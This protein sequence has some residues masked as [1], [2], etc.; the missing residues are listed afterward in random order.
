MLLSA[1]R[2][3][4]DAVY[5]KDCRGR[6]ASL[7]DNNSMRID[8]ISSRIEELAKM[9]EDSMGGDI[10]GNINKIAKYLDGS[11]DIKDFP[12]LEGSDIIDVNTDDKGEYTTVKEAIKKLYDQRGGAGQTGITYAGNE[13]GYIKYIKKQTDTTQ[14]EN[15]IGH[16]PT[17]F[18][19]IYEELNYLCKHLFER[20]DNLDVYEGMEVK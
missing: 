20:D 19:I 17:I 13:D 10:P 18:P 16:Y 15:N 14:Y 2:G 12:H 1:I 8:L 9:I 7:P 5:Y 6:Y 4:E 3:L 11:T